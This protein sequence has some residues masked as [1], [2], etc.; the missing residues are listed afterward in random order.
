MK[1]VL[2]MVRVFVCGMLAFSFA[3]CAKPKDKIESVASNLSNSTVQTE[4]AEEFATIAEALLQSSR[5]DLAM[6]EFEKSLEINP[7]NARANFYKA[8]LSSR[9]ILSSLIAKEPIEE[10]EAK[11]TEKKS[12]ARIFFQGLDQ[13]QSIELKQ[14]TELTELLRL[15]IEQ[16]NR[17]SKAGNLVLNQ[18]KTSLLDSIDPSTGNNQCEISDEKTIKCFVPETE[19]KDAGKITIKT[20]EFQAFNHLIESLIT[21]INTS[22]S[23]S[24]T[25]LY[26]VLN[27]TMN[28]QTLKGEVSEITF[29]K[30]LSVQASKINTK[31]TEKDE[32]S[33][34]DLVQE[35][36]AT[37][38]ETTLVMEQLLCEKDKGMS[39]RIE[40]LI[41]LCTSISLSKQIPV[42]MKEAASITLGKSAKNSSEVKIK[43]HLS[44]FLTHSLAEIQELYFNKASTDTTLKDKAFL[45][46]FPDQDFLAKVNTV[47]KSEK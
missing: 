44:K 23:Y 31:I 32:D 47:A 19:N 13:F 16:M 22:I 38:Q 7:D 28:E 5:P 42:L 14:R 20:A 46:L 34:F 8:L 11:K 18:G 4:K 2:P 10:Q 43:A 15:S 40:F 33:E 39:S 6:K 12:P 17:A 26:D 27:N 45:G 1:L 24:Q 41:P 30:L 25:Y 9:S 36:Q 37:T 29:L 3:S 35:V 21:S